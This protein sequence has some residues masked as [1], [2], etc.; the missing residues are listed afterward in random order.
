MGFLGTT[1]FFSF[2]GGETS[3]GE[4]TTLG[5]YYFTSFT[6]LSSLNNPYNILFKSKSDEPLNPLIDLDAFFMLMKE[7]N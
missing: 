5:T 4:S 2:L 3:A 6:N 7:S 1:L